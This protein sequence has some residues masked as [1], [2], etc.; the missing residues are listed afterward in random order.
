ML[1][2]HWLIFMEVEYWRAWAWHENNQLNPFLSILSGETRMIQIAFSLLYLFIVPCLIIFFKFLITPLGTH[3]WDVDSFFPAPF[4]LPSFLILLKHYLFNITTHYII[5][6]F[7][8]NMASK[9]CFITNNFH[10][11]NFRL[12]Q[13]EGEN[14]VG[15]K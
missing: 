13:K 6:C 2:Y 11:H 10:Y 14:V 9:N 1:N 12:P 3:W 8:Q 15:E 7:V 5:L 4:R